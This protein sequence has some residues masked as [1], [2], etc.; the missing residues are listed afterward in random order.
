MGTWVSYALLAVATNSALGPPF[1]PVL[2]W[3]ASGRPSTQAWGF[4]VVGSLCAGTAAALEVSVGRRLLNWRAGSSS[5]SR[6]CKGRVFYLFAAAVAASPVPFT[7]VRGAAL[8]RRPRPIAYG[9][10]VA[11]GR[12]P[13]YALTVLAWNRLGLLG[14]AVGV[15]V[16][17]GLIVILAWNSG[18]LTPS[19]TR[20]LAVGLAPDPRA[21]PA[22]ESEATSAA[23]G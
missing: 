18:L 8:S 19:R 23:R 15:V 16:A 17:G 14:G 1:D 3:Y 5:V 2:L 12:L 7:V 4:I 20:P 11:A 13:R 10:C 6:S 22:D 9:T 21:V